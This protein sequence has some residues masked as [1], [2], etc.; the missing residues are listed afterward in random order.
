MPCSTH[1][2][3]T[4]ILYIYII[5]ACTYIHIF[6]SPLYCQFVHG[7]HMTRLD[8][9]SRKFIRCQNHA[10]PKHLCHLLHSCQAEIETLTSKME[11]DTASLH[12]SKKASMSFC[13]YYVHI[14]LNFVYTCWSP[15]TL[16]VCICLKA[17]VQSK[18]VRQCHVMSTSTIHAAIWSQESALTTEDISKLSSEVTAQ[19]RC[20]FFVFFAN[21]EVWW[22]TSD[23]KWKLK[24]THPTWSINK[25]IIDWNRWPLL[26]W[27]KQPRF[28]PMSLQAMRPWTVDF[29]PDVG[30][31]VLLCPS[32]LFTLFFLHLSL[33]ELAWFSIF[34]CLQLLFAMPL[35]HAC[36]WKVALKEAKAG[37]ASADFALKTLRLGTLS[38]GGRLKQLCTT[39]TSSLP[40]HLNTKFLIAYRANAAKFLRL[41]ATGGLF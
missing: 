26:S 7:L 32:Y 14:C 24:H 3:I 39:K 6:M 36:L 22:N 33:L 25:L 20:V 5:L 37:K 9:I 34:I 4:V 10:T 11:T 13:S 18:K 23:N 21:R 8:R 31:L 28:E 12:Q 27:T 16:F 35:L 40:Q 41:V 30:L 2:N 19:I 38:L 15:V 29:C 1:Y 17:I